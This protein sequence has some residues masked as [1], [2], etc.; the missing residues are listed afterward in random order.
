MNTKDITDSAPSNWQPITNKHDL[1][2]LGKLGEEANEL[3]A[4]ISRCIIQGIDEK[5]PITGKINKQ[6][7]E[8]EISDVYALAFLAIKRLNLDNLA[9][10]DRSARKIDHKE[11]WFNALKAGENKV[12]E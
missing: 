12:G 11:K 2:V 4:A 7:L 10:T 5:E 6:W 9:I 1:A 8:E 3:G